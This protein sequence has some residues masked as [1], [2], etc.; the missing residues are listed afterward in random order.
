MKFFH[1]SEEGLSYRNKLRLRV[2]KRFFTNEYKNFNFEIKKSNPNLKKKFN[3]LKNKNF[4]NEGSLL[5]KKNF[6]KQ[7]FSKK[8]VPILSTEYLRSY[9]FSKQYGNDF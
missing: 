5:E 1:D 7:I 4:K 2:E 6:E 3:F 8:I 9:F